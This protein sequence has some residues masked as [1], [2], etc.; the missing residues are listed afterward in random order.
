MKQGRVAV[1]AGL[2]LLVGCHPGAPAAN[3]TP[4]VPIAAASGAAAEPDDPELL[5]LLREDAV[6][7]ARWARRVLYSWTT[8]AQAE[9]LH[10]QPWLL[11]RVE[12]PTRGPALFDQRMREALAGAV[13][14]LFTRR[15]LGFRR[16]AWVAPWATHSGID[17]ERYGDVLVRVELKPEAIVAR[18]DSRSAQRWSFQT[19][20]G[21]AVDEK[22][23]LAHPERI[24]A[25]Y[26]LWYGGDDNTGSE[27]EARYPFREYVL[28]NESMIA[29][30]ELDTT[31]IDER[32]ARDQRLLGAMQSYLQGHPLAP[33]KSWESWQAAVVDGWS[34]P[35]GRLVRAYESALAF[36]SPEYLSRAENVAAQLIGLGRVGTGAVPLVHA[37]T[38]SFGE[39]PPTAVPPTFIPGPARPCRGTMCR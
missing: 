27:S 23:V 33:P 25:V 13:G 1:G 20:S 15:E 10:T 35:G 4:T 39:I 9:E 14:Q 24:G 22:E 18:Y 26:H 2:S 34:A 16:F 11:T 30:W 37:P 6:D 17:D 31:E 12:S 19:V 5:A 8:P 28:C 38:A 36:A 29:S 3:A 32:I 21:A 7:P